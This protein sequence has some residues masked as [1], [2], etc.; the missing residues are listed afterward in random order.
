[1]TVHMCT[2]LRGMHAS[3]PEIYASQCS[4][5]DSKLDSVSDPNGVAQYDHSSCACSSTHLSSA[6][7]P[8]FISG[9][10]YTWFDLPT[11]YTCNGTS[12]HEWSQLHVQQCLTEN[13][14]YVNTLTRR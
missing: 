12:L 14:L 8:L 11:L 2:G 5:Q 6:T 13:T 7:A 9:H 1:M 4:L 3:M 10:N